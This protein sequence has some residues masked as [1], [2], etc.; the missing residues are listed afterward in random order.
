MAEPLTINDLVPQVRRER[1][2]TDIGYLAFPFLVEPSRT[3]DSSHPQAADRST[4]VRQEIEQ[5]LFTAPGERPHR[6]DWGIGVEQLVFEPGADSLRAMINQRLTSTLAEVLRGEV[7]PASIGVDVSLRDEATLVIRVS[8]ALATINRQ[9]EHL[10]E[11]AVG[12]G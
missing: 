6:P 8:Y 1:R 9:V 10:F 4:H 7:D 5:V 2:L 12:R 11:K 3:D